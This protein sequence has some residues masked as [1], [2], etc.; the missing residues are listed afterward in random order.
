MR[1]PVEQ[2]YYW[3]DVFYNICCRIYSH[4]TRIESIS[5]KSLNEAR[6]LLE[7]PDF[8]LLIRRFLPLN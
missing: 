1:H 8:H 7:K 5:I 6:P 4:G 2:G 3:P